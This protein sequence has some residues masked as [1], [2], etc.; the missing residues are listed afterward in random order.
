MHG[1][2]RIDFQ[3]GNTRGSKIRESSEVAGSAIASTPNCL[4]TLDSIVAMLIRKTRLAETWPELYERASVILDAVPL[5]TAERNL[6]TLRLQNSHA[7]S[8]GLQFGAAMFELRLLRGQ[9]SHAHQL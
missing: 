7:Y 2:T 3:F 1:S 5:T 8:V 6:A 4:D 9:F